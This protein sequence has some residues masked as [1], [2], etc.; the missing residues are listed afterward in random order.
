[1]SPTGSDFS[2]GGHLN[3]RTRYGPVDFLGT[4]GPKLSYEDLVPDSLETKIG[5]G[6]SVRVLNLQTIISTKEHV[7]SEKDLA[8]LPLLRQTLSEAKKKA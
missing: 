7:G 4:I 3:L 8:V 5:E 2:R 1:M 6:I